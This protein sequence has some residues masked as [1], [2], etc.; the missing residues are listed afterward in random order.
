MIGIPTSLHEPLRQALDNLGDLSA[1][2]ST[3]PVSGGCINHAARL[4]TRD[5][6]YLLK[7]NADPLPDMFQCELRGLLLL[8]STRTV[9]VPAPFAAVEAGKSHPAFILLEFLEGSGIAGQAELGEQLASLHAKGASPQVPPAYGLDEDNYLGSTVQK[10]GWV[11]SWPEFFAVYRLIPQMELAG[12]NG[13]LL[14]ER[15]RRL[16]RLIERLPDLLGSG[17]Q[18]PSLIHGDLWNGNVIPGPDGLALIDPAVSYS[19]REAEIAYTELFGGFV[20]RFYV[21]YNQAWPL[22]PGYTDRRDLYNLY[23]LLNHLNLFGES[24]GFQVDAV[25]RRYMG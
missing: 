8:A 21:A 3:T 24:Y 14:P 25:L 11:N 6:R 22:N 23:H 10:N 4:E 5:H 15:R 12:N 16:E 17:E 19:D 2:L 13:R 9:R 20:P 18:R 7:W 1:V